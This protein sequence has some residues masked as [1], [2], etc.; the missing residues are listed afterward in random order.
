MPFDEQLDR[1]GGV[2]MPIDLLALVGM[3][4]LLDEET[5]AMWNRSDHPFSARVKKIRGLLDWWQASAPEGTTAEKA[6]DLRDQHNRDTLAAI[7]WAYI[8]R[9]PD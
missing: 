5:M 6:L 4:R 8:G 9:E 3:A 1:F 2:Q 7:G